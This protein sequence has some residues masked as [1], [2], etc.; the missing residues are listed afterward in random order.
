M[1]IR[2]VNGTFKSKFVHSFLFFF[3]LIISDSSYCFTCC[4]TRLLCVAIEK[5]EIVCFELDIM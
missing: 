3:L 5:F 2:V 4:D 1:A